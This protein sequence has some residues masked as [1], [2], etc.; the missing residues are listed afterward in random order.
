MAIYDNHN[1]YDTYLSNT[2]YTL[3]LHIVH[4]A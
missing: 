1:H 3:T 4:V 2:D